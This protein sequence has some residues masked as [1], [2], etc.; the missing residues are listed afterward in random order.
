MLLSHWR[1]CNKPSDT[2]CIIS[3]PEHNVRVFAGSV[4]AVAL[5]WPAKQ[6][7]RLCSRFFVQTVCRISIKFLIDI[8]APKSRM[9]WTEFVALGGGESED[10]NLVQAAVDRV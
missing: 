8:V 7:S 1:T 2:R 10:V 5:C 3:Y 9:M 6:S 4:A